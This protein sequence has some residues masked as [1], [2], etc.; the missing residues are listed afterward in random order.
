M[1]IDFNALE[2]E[3]QQRWPLEE[4]IAGYGG[5]GAA[6]AVGAAGNTL[7]RMLRTARSLWPVRQAAKAGRAVPALEEAPA[8]AQGAGDVA[9]GL[10][11]MISNYLPT[12]E[13][14]GSVVA[15]TAPSLRSIE[16]ERA[17][18]WDA[19]QNLGWKKW[20][21][22]VP[23]APRGT[24]ALAIRTP[25]VNKELYSLLHPSRRPFP[26]ETTG[27]FSPHTNV[28][29]YAKPTQKMTL[30]HEGTH[31]ARYDAPKRL[32]PKIRQALSDITQKNPKAASRLRKSELYRRLEPWRLGEEILAYNITKV[33]PKPG[34]A[35]HLLKQKAYG[36]IQP[37]HYQDAWR[38]PLEIPYTGALW[39]NQ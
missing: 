25:G 9:E 11:R 1:P 16:G 37:E 31:W 8:M 13:Q 10:K 24:E 19:L 3:A 33:M 26:K 17:A 7:G 28:I 21:L 35:S 23:V 39:G 15:R 30:P 20:L 27:W 22:D 12:G 32:Q 6:P 2:R 4:M 36:M 18:T 34:T 38:L 14:S 5:G 29:A